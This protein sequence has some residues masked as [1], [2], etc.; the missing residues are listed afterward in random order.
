MKKFYSRSNHHFKVIFFKS[1]PSWL[2]CCSELS[3]ASFPAILVRGGWTFCSDIVPTCSAS[4]QCLIVWAW[5]QQEELPGPFPAGGG[6]HT[7]SR[8]EFWYLGEL[9]RT[10]GL[11]SWG[12]KS[13]LFLILILLGKEAEALPEREHRST[14]WLLLWMIQEGC[15]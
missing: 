14:I 2:C 9:V 10:D 12:A 8:R 7:T 5:E 1:N 3:Y 6:P 4:P 11:C 15:C 13:I